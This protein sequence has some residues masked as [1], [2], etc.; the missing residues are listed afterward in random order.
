M[1]RADPKR[2]IRVTVKDLMLYPQTKDPL[3]KGI[4]NDNFFEDSDV[5][6]VLKETFEH[7]QASIGLTLENER[8][9]WKVLFKILFK[10]YWN[11]ARSA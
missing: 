9:F 3:L 10:E 6:Q 11:K 2:R 4:F 8:Y 7:L 1:F 5:K